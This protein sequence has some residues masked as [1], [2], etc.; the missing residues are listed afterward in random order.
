MLAG[1]TK[2]SR[3]NAHGDCYLRTEEPSLVRKIWLVMA[4]VHVPVHFLLIAALVVNVTEERATGG[5]FIAD[6]RNDDESPDARAGYAMNLVTNEGDLRM[7]AHLI[8]K[9]SKRIALKRT[10]E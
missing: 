2:H 6:S 8:R 1:R 5:G 9:P 7:Q 10:L 4:R 3:A